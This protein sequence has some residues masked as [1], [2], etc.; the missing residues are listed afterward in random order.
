MES[1]LKLNLSAGL[2][3]PKLEEVLIPSEDFNLP[4]CKTEINGVDLQ[5]IWSEETEDFQTEMNIRKLEYF[6]KLEIDQL[7]YGN[8]AKIYNHILNTENKRLEPYKIF[9][10]PE[11][12]ISI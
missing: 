3:I 8:C 5:Y 10:L 12:L 9:E 7:A 4:N 2:V 11:G 6:G 1:A